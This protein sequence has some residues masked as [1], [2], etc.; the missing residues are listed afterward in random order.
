MSIWRRKAIELFPEKKKEFEHS[1]GPR[2]AWIYI[3]A[4]LLEYLQASDEDHIKRVKQYFSWSIN[5]DVNS[6]PHQ[7]ALCGFL[8]TIGYNKKYWPYFRKLLTIQQFEKYK[9]VLS[10][11]INSEQEKQMEN[12]FYCK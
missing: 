7:A 11:L 9:N 12:T 10:F 8:E 1:V 3:E 5:T 6:I 4:D 2:E